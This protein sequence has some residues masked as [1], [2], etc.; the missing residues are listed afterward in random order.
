MRKDAVGLVVEKGS[1]RGGN[2]GAEGPAFAGKAP[3]RR[4]N[5]LLC[6]SARAAAAAAE[7]IASKRS[8]SGV[9]S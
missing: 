9:S 4:L 2:F 7:A 1:G 8:A 5:F 3:P 6:S